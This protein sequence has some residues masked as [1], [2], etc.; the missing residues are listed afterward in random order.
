MKALVPIIVVPGAAT[1][2]ITLQNA[3]DFFEKGQWVIARKKE[4]IAPGTIV[5]LNRALKK[6]DGCY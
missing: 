6:D 5:T 3:Q 4:A 2:N 1:S